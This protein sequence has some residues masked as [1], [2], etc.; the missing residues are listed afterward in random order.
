VKRW[1]NRGLKFVK[2]ERVDKIQVQPGTSGGGEA[3][4]ATLG[5][6][7]FHSVL[8]DNMF[9]LRAGNRDWLEVHIRTVWAE[10]GPRRR[11]FRVRLL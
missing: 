8:P 9:R 10:G 3:G 5:N 11:P 1:G 4:G 6:Q 7:D 2:Y